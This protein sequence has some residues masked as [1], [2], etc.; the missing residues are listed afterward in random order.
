MLLPRQDA[1]LGE[2]TKLDGFSLVLLAAAL[3]CL[4][5]GLKEAPH[6]GW[7]SP[8]LHR[9]VVG[10]L[11]RSRPI[12]VRRTLRAAHPVVRA[13]DAEAALLRGRL[14]AELLLGVGLFG[15]VYLMPVFL[16]F[17][18]GHDAFEIGTIMLVTGDRATR[19]RA[20]RGDAGKPARR[21]RC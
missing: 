18:R 17:V 6:R 2:L 20:G 5:I 3:A 4:E 12:F 14:R 1:D 19:H 10:Q 9:P 21:A 16:A 13:L 7:L 15:S 11:C 8:H